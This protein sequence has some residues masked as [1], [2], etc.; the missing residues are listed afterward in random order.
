MG[1]CLSTHHE[2]ISHGIARPGVKIRFQVLGASRAF[3]I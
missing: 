2:G 3:E 1:S